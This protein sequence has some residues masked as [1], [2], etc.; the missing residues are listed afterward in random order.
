MH[1]DHP[2]TKV[3]FWAICRQLH[4]KIWPNTKPIEKMVLKE[5][6][7]ARKLQTNKKSWMKLPDCG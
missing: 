5:R 3:F 7:I 6:K 1:N 2:T 4:Q